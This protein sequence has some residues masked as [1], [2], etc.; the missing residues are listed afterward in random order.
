MVT[1]AM[2][3]RLV[4]LRHGATEWS[5]AGRHTGRS[6]VALVGVGRAQAEAVRPL[7]GRF[8]FALVL[9]SP[10]QRAA[11]TCALAG[12]AGEP[13]PDLVEWDYGEYEGRT[14]DEIRQE[15]PGWTL[16]TDGVPGGEGAA[17]VGRRADRVIERARSVP[18]DTLCVAHGHLLRVLTARWLELPPVA[19]RLFALEAGAVGVLGWEREVPTVER[20]NLGSLG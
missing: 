18:G 12:Y 17:D 1:Y 15:H 6:D 11:E 3:G 4:L 10:L 2:P 16:W 5:L 13:E 9:T 8:D 19:G 14:T 20:W 7:L